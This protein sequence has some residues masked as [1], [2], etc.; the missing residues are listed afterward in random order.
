MDVTIVLLYS[1]FCYNLFHAK[2]NSL[3]VLL[4]AIRQLL[5][6][7][8]SQPGGNTVAKGHVDQIDELLSVVLYV[9]VKKFDQEG[10]NGEYIGADA[11]FRV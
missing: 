3:L 1:L 6:L 5:S 2:Y 9:V 7:D 10:V 4:L 11:H 8:V